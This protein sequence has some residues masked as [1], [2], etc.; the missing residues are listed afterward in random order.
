MSLYYLGKQ[1]NTI[2]TMEAA[3]YQGWRE[4]L[5][6][7][8]VGSPKVGGSLWRSQYVE[9]KDHV[10]DCGLWLLEPWRPLSGQPTACCEWFPAHLG[11]SPE[12]VE[13]TSRI[14]QAGS[15]LQFLTCEME[16]IKASAPQRA[17]VRIKW[18]DMCTRT[19][20]GMLFNAHE[21][22]LKC[23]IIIYCFNSFYEL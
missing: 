9:H 1:R 23:I 8:N 20:P 5:V 17:E 2:K 12:W 4:S 18:R 6:P 19:E 16:I 15:L 11:S 3:A 10:L 13:V 7:L 22:S 21:I 14:L